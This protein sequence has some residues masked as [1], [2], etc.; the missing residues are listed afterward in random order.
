MSPSFTRA[1]DFINYVLT[2]FYAYILTDVADNHDAGHFSYD[3]I[4]R[5][6]STY[7]ELHIAT[8]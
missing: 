8:Q 7:T 1:E 6:R 5:S 3:G 4:D 2:Q